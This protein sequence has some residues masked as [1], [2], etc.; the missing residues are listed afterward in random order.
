MTNVRFQEKQEIHT[1]VEFEYPIDNAEPC[2]PHDTV[3]GSHL[4]DECR[5]IVWSSVGHRLVHLVTDRA[6]LLTDHKMSGLPI[7]AK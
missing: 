7:L 5:K 2:F 1:E 6:S 4:C 3:V